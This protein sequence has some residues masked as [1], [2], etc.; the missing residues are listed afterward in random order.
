M[1]SVSSG[2][3][4]RMS[5]PLQKEIKE[6]STCWIVCVVCFED[7]WACSLINV[8]SSSILM[9]R[10]PLISFGFARFPAW[11]GNGHKWNL[12]VC[13]V[14]L[15]PSGRTPHTVGPKLEYSLFFIAM[16][17]LSRF[18][19]ITILKSYCVVTLRRTE[20][21]HLCDHIVGVAYSCFF[22]W[23]FTNIW[24]NIS[25][26]FSSSCYAWIWNTVDPDILGSLWR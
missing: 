23:N 14:S 11:P 21:N 4:G 17:G 20:S 16:C 7:K 8:R 25:V 3:L 19:S 9:Y 12:Q 26:F 24:F 6:Y 2:H 10:S 22:L 13:G 15:V 5:G 18:G 1:C